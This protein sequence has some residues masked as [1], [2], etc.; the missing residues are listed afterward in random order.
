[1]IEILYEYAG[2]LML[3]LVYII[4]TLFGRKKTA[5]DVKRIA[6][7]KRDKALVKASKLAVKSDKQC[8]KAEKIDNEV[9]SND[10]VN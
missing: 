1:M 4:C 5:E 8:A 7:K 2:E 9:L 3:A 10:S 6:E